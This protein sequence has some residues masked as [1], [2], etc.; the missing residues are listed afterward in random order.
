M[1]PT[2]PPLLVGKRY[3]WLVRAVPADPNKAYDA[4]RNNGYSDVFSF[5]YKPSLPK[6]EIEVFEIEKNSLSIEWS[7]VKDYTGLYYVH[8][9]YNGRMS[10]KTATSHN[11]L[12]I[13]DIQKELIPELNISTHG[14]KRITAYVT[15]FSTSGEIVAEAIDYFNIDSITPRKP[16]EGFDFKITHVPE[17]LF[18]EISN[19]SKADGSIYKIYRRKQGE[20]EFQLLSTHPPNKDTFL[21]AAAKSDT[22]YIYAVSEVKKDGKESPKEEK[23]S[24]VVHIDDD[25]SFKKWICVNGGIHAGIIGYGGSSEADRNPFT[26]SIAGNLNVKLFDLVTV[27]ISM[28]ISNGNR[29]LNLAVTPTRFSMSPRYK[30]ATTHIGDVNLTYSPY[31][32]NGHQFTGGG[33]DIE[34]E[35]NKVKF[36]GMFGRMQREVDYD[37]SK[38]TQISSYERWGMGGKLQYERK[39]FDLGLNV[40]TAKDRLKAKE[41]PVDPADITP[42]QNL[43]GSLEFDLRPFKGFEFKSEYAI[44]ALTT[45]LLDTTP[46]AVRETGAFNNIYP[47]NNSTYYAHASKFS[48]NYKIKRT[49]VGL[50][51][52]KIDPG[53]RTLGAYFFAN[54]LENFTANFVKVFLDN[55][56]NIKF[57][58]GL[59]RDNLDG[60]KSGTNERIVGDIYLN[61]IPN[62]KFNMSIDYSNFRTY[63]RINSQFQF[64]NILNQFQALDT[65]NFTQIT[66]DLNVALNYKIKEGK[67]NTHSLLSTLSL[68]DAYSEQSGNELKDMSNI[69]YNG[70]ISYMYVQKQIKLT[71]V[72]TYLA[73]FNTI[74]QDEFVTQGPAVSIANKLF[75]ELFEIDFM[76]N[77]NNTATNNPAIADV[78]ILNFRLGLDALMFRKHHVSASI[79]HQAN[80]KLNNQIGNVMY[81]FYF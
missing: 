28:N 59:Q 18:L 22:A 26:Y 41:A 39:D 76:F 12:T 24:D 20:P 2:S 64:V 47:T 37:T 29:N 27:P 43:V 21:D 45:D 40:F 36:R 35:K 67:R 9:G 48:F 52:E 54:D 42:Q 63:M 49:T 69:F 19:A 44:S 34:P 33:L 53:Y 81:N 72:T 3:A 4:F 61:I 79:T 32:L 71:L 11:N 65:F 50:G 8:F 23:A 62:K 70:N 7:R 10:Q 16:D 66:Q 38:P 77:Y 25:F 58:A 51:Y 6:F 55:K 73:T 13:A 60:L 14:R 15:Y 74:A 80:G 68:Q 1:D 56:L 30:A 57:I 46:V 5:Y 75:K 17:G 31:T 78:N